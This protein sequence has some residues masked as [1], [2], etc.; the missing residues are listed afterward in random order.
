M[1]EMKTSCNIRSSSDLY[2]RPYLKLTLLHF[3]SRANRETNQYVEIQIYSCVWGGGYKVEC[4][5]RM[6]GVRTD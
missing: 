2:L 5:W 4:V 6:G 3:P 1:R